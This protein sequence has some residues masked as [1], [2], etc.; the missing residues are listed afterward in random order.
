MS[1]EEFSGLSHDLTMAVTEREFGA[2][3]LLLSR[4]LLDIETAIPKRFPEVVATL[5]A[6]ISDG[7]ADREAGAALMYILW[8]LSLSIS[9]HEVRFRAAAGSHRLVVLII[10]YGG[11]CTDDLET[12]ASWYSSQG[13]AVISTSPLSWPPVI[14]ERHDAMMA[15]KLQGALQGGRRLLLHVCSN[16]GAMRAS[17]LLGRWDAAVVPFASL[18]RPGDCVAGFVFECAPAKPMDPVTGEVCRKQR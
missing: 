15:E 8:M 13:L 6:R 17:A 12:Q 11:S 2:V 14:A 10:G 1:D 3:V 5:M 18:P 7:V 16:G 9:L 4:A